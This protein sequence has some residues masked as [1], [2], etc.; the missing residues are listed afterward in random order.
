MDE[1]GVVVRNK[2]KLV[3]QWY[4]QE[5]VTDFDETFETCR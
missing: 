5:E 2:I 1:S 3:A 4:N